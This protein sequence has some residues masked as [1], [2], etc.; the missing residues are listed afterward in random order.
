MKNRKH[1]RQWILIIIIFIL[2]SRGIAQAIGIETIRAFI[3]HYPIFA[4]LVIIAIKASTVVFAPL[5]GIAIFVAA[6]A[7]FP[8]RE[9]LIYMT[10]GNTIGFVVAYFLWK[11]FGDKIILRMFGQHWLQKAHEI[12]D[13]LRTPKTFIITRI[14]LFRLEDLINYTAGMVK[15]PFR[16]FFIVSFIVSTI[17][18]AFRVL[19]TAGI[20]S[21][22]F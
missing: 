21:I 5:S 18:T 8:W 1:I 19:S 20:V 6:W 22:K 13:R 17:T 10:I 9:A 4:P 14:V 16:L 7:I 2:I 11:K 12:I 15:T 3:A